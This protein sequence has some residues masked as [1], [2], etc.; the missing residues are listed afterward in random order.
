MKRHNEEIATKWEEGWDGHEIAQRRRLARVPLW[1][2]LDWL[3][4]AQR[5]A[6]HLNSRRPEELP[7][8][9]AEGI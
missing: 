2:I 8:G 3:E 4:E 9:Q 6:R 1:E 7:E 5:I